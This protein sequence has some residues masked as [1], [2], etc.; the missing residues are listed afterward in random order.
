MRKNGYSELWKNVDFITD[1]RRSFE[2]FFSREVDGGFSQEALVEHFGMQKHRVFDGLE[3]ARN[4]R[5]L[6]H[7]AVAKKKMSKCEFFEY[8]QQNLK[9]FCEDNYPSYD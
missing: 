4:L 1:T 2:H 5:D 8:S 7:R 3:D 9:K 6:V